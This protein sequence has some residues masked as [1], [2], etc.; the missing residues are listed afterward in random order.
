MRNRHHR[1]NRHNATLSRPVRA[2]TVGLHIRVATAGSMPPAEPDCSLGSVGQLLLRCNR[3]MPFVATPHPLI[4]RGALWLTIGCS[5]LVGPTGCHRQ[6]YRRQADCEANRLLDQKSA[7]VARSPDRPLRIEPDRRSRY[8]NPFDLD[9]QPRPVDDPAAHPYMRCV[10][11]RRGYPMW[12]AAGITNTAESPDWYRFLPL[13]DDGVLTLN[14]ENAVQIALLH[15]PQFQSNLEDLYL[16]ALD[17]SNERFVFDTQYFSGIEA[18]FNFDRNRLRERNGNAVVVDNDTFALGNARGLFGNGPD[19]FRIERRFATGGTLVAGVANNILFDLTGN[20]PSDSTNLFDFTL[21][22]PLLRGAGRDLVLENLTLSER[23]LLASVRAFERFRREFFLQVTTGRN[24]DGP[25]GGVA[26]ANPGA[27]LPTIGTGGGGGG[28]GR[29]GGFLGLLQAQLLIRNQEENIARLT[30]SVLI[31]E[32]SLIES[33]TTIPDDTTSIIRERLQIAQARQELNRSQQTLVS[34][35]ADYEFAVDQFLGVLGLP[36]YLCVRIVDDQLSQF[37]LIDRQLLRRREQISAIRT[38]VGDI[39]VGILDESTPAIDPVTDLPRI[40][41]EYS[42][43]LQSRLESFLGEISPLV[44]FAET[45]LKDDVPRVQTDLTVLADAVPRRRAANRL[46]AEA[47]EANRTSICGIL[48]IAEIDDAL[49]ETGEL[50]GL[51]DELTES[52]A[53][54][55][56][57]LDQATDGVDT[58]RQSIDE[59]ILGGDDLTSAD[60]SDAIRDEVILYAQDLL[61]NL[62]D[63]V[64]ALQL[65]QARARTESVVLP[66]VDLQ[67]AA[68]FNIA[69]QNRRDYANAKM[70]LVDS[71]RNIEV[72]ADDLESNLDLVVR[73]GLQNNR[74]AFRFRDDDTSVRVGLRFDAPLTRLIERNNYRN[75][76]IQFERDKRALYSFEDDIWRTLR[77]EL[78]SL[79]ANRLNFEL[80]REAVRIAAAQIDLNN[81]TRLLNDARGEGSGPTAARDTITALS[82]LLNAQNNLLGTFI[83][84]EIIRRTLDLDLGTMELTPE[85]LW[86]DPVQ[87][88]AELLLTQPGTEIYPSSGCHQCGLPPANPP[89]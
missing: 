80:G 17:V 56:E 30:E 87:F 48:N 12:D 65:I 6:Y 21:L 31:L 51:G 84:Y 62:S 79:K 20:G 53:T 59:L 50:E 9:F 15:S 44:G 45:L 61:A 33:L 23:Q 16:S 58:L 70:S 37:N 67:P 11:D 86:L 38:R 42:P 40:A 71:W 72:V 35:Q 3:L 89:F 57:Q 83:S 29:I 60:L 43:R 52:F 7:T 4:A 27:F 73:G 39:A 24:P 2:A 22:Q 10:D 47:V 18:A 64:L 19:S 66:P 85:G 88:D 78:R 49:F 34:Q 36:P 14:A 8:F 76:L 82:A 63:Q 74:N 81:D 55:V 41:F 1:T 13:D 5:I 54:I 46:M 28:V 69:I 32:D 68:A 25:P 26:V 75:A 77:D